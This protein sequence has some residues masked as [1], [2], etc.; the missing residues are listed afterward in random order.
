MV[1]LDIFAICLVSFCVVIFVSGSETPLNV[2]IK[3]TAVR[4][5]TD[6]L[7]SN[8]DIELLQ[9]LVRDPSAKGLVTY[10]DG[11]RVEGEWLRR[12]STYFGSFHQNRRMPNLEFFH[13]ELGDRLVAWG[14]DRI[15]YSG[16]RNVTFTL[17]YPRGGIGAIIS[18]Y[19][20][21]VDMV[22]SYGSM[23][24]LFFFFHLVNFQSSNYGNAYIDSG[25]IGETHITIVIEAYNTRWFRYIFAIHG[26][27]KWMIFSSFFL[28][29]ASTHLTFVCLEHSVRPKNA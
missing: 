29:I 9:P 14:S 4:N 12:V 7:K 11:E 20:V 19:E 16:V 6:F 1:Q 15:E 10:K 8:P 21:L 24:H 28:S 13:F 27:W 22:S 2:N 3:F 17:T 26:Y 5:L 18:Y 25:G 23:C